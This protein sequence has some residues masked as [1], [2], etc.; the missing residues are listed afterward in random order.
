MGIFELNKTAITMAKTIDMLRKLESE[1]HSY[2]D[3]DDN[4]DDFYFVA[5][6]IRVGILDRIEVNNWPLTCPISIP[7]GMF[8]VNKVSIAQGLEM[9]VGRLRE[10][11]EDN[12]RVSYDVRKILNKEGLFWEFEKIIPNDK[13][14][15]L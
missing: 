6:M 15:L 9:T 5:Y 3:I 4:K 1:S 11:L 2:F 8:G 14:A 13:K 7:K 12:L 10:M